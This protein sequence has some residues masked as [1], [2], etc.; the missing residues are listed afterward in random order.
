[1]AV[2]PGTVRCWGWSSDG[3][4]VVYIY[5]GTAAH[6]LL[7]GVQTSEELYLSVL[8]VRWCVESPAC[9]ALKAKKTELAWDVTVERTQWDP[10]ARGRD[11]C[12]AWD[13]CEL[14]QAKKWLSW[15]DCLLETAYKECSRGRTAQGLILFF[16]LWSRYWTEALALR[17]I[18]TWVGWMCS[19]LIV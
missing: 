1:M 2:I 17:R 5:V 11:M 16:C 18:L 14:Y 8:V 15:T 7:R 4:S 19:L 6:P 12:S 9:A 3:G 13:A 10:D